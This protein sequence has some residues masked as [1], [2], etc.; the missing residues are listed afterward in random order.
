M[1][2]MME[3]MMTGEHW[4]LLLIHIPFSHTTTTN[5]EH[6]ACADKATQEKMG[7]LR[8]LL[9]APLAF[10]EDIPEN[11]HYFGPE[12]PQRG[13]ESPLHLPFPARF[14]HRSQR[15]LLLFVCLFTSRT[16]CA[17][18][19]AQRGSDLQMEMK[20]IT[21]SACRTSVHRR[22]PGGGCLTAP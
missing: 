10:V 11:K 6:R 2:M 8:Y 7:A 4:P 14:G 16:C 13:L 21:S 5:H 15:Y 1:E 22:L 18:T 3:M 19:D 9:G 20:E 17:R 12:Q